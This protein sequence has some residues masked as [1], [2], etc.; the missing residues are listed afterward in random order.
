MYCS[1]AQP[2]GHFVAQ[3]KVAI[4]IGLG[5]L[6]VAT[7]WGALVVGVE[8]ADALATG[9][10]LVS[11]A[12]GGAACYLDGRDCINDPGI[13]GHCLGLTLGTIGVTWPSQNLQSARA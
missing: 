11:L 2:V 13:N 6:S 5:I 10:G 9:L 4:G 3:H 7:G 12:S 8:G 1:V